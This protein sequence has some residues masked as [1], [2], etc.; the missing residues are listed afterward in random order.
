MSA[1]AEVRARIID[2]ARVAWHDAI[3]A[4]DKAK[5]Y[6]ETLRDGQ[7]MHESD[8]WEAIGAIDGMT[9]VLTDLIEELEE[10]QP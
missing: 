7:L 5:G 2:E 8:S 4:L 6:V 9:T 3:S 1:I 10:L